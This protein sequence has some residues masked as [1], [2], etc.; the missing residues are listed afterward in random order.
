M[1]TRLSARYHF[2]PLEACED[3][4]SIPLVCKETEAWGDKNDFGQDLLCLAV[5]IPTPYLSH[6]LAPS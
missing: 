5:R 4:I 6:A 3:D 1:P 2:S